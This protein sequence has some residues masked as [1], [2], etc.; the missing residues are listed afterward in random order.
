M[1]VCAA[2]ARFELWVPF[3]SCRAHG[4]KFVM[5]FSGML[6]EQSA[7][8]LLFLLY[9]DS[10]FMS[11]KYFHNQTTYNKDALRYYC[12]LHGKERKHSRFWVLLSDVHKGHGKIFA[13]WL[14]CLCDLVWLLSY[15]LLFLRSIS[16]QCYNSFWFLVCW[17]IHLRQD[18]FHFAVS[19]ETTINL[20]IFLYDCYSTFC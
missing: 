13:G 11:Q 16:H 6:Q 3:P 15:H 2:I 4:A 8:L 5:S 17:E 12:S 18:L 9:F 10:F 7:C 1:P 19:V 20:S 14:N